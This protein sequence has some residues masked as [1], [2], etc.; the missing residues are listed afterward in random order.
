MFGCSVLMFMFRV[1]LNILICFKLFVCHFFWTIL[2]WHGCLVY[3][4]SEKNWFSYL[5]VIQKWKSFNIEFLFWKFNIFVSWTFKFITIAFYAIYIF[6]FLFFIIFSLVFLFYINTPFS[7]SRLIILISE[8][9]KSF[10]WTIKVL[11]STVE[12]FLLPY[13]RWP[14]SVILFDTSMFLLISM[15]HYNYCF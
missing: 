12:H 8:L 4:L 5:I 11:L 7:F 10:S 2:T 3:F 1:A 6:L 13:C 14:F 9:L 15:H